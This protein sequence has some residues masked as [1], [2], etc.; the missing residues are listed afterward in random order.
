MQGHEYANFA[1]YQIE[2]VLLHGIAWAAHRLVD[3][4]VDYIPPPSTHPQPA[5]A[6]Q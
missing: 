6:P 2:Q 5:A 1:N 3:T 4:L